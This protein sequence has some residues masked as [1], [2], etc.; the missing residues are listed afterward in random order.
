MRKKS[1]SFGLKTIGYVAVGCVGLYFSMFL[2][3]SVV[4]LALAAGIAAASVILAP[5]FIEALVYGKWKAMFQMWRGNPVFALYR[6]KQDM[7]DELKVREVAVTRLSKSVHLNISR[8]NQR[9]H[10]HPED[11]ARLAPMVE[12]TYVVV[13]ASYAGRTAGPISFSATRAYVIQRRIPTG[14]LKQVGQSLSAY[15]RTCL[16]SIQSASGTH[17]AWNT[18]SATSVAVGTQLIDLTAGPS[19][20]CSR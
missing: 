16:D 12:K 14:P 3:K 17:Q 4:A 13:K 6:N 8:L 10:T 15:V 19:P 7:L 1:R 11:A 2:L 18:V 20:I 5:A 9:Q